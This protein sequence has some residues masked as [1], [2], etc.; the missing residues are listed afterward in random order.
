MNVYIGLIFPVKKIKLIKS[1]IN[2]KNL[3]GLKP[4][5]YLQP[6]DFFLSVQRLYSARPNQLINVLCMSVYN[7]TYPQSQPFAHLPQ[8]SL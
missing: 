7:Y 8:H 3:I 5:L 4:R 6:C 1:R 2:K